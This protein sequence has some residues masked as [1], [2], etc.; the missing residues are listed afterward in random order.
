MFADPQFVNVSSP[1]ANLDIAT[2]SPAANAGTN[3]GVNTVGVLD[4]R[5]IHE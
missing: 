2:S 4:Y 3:L 1:P 5:A